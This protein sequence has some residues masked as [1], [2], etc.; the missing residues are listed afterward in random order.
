MNDGELG[1]DMFVEKIRGNN[2]RR[3]ADIKNNK[4][5]GQLPAL[6]KCHFTRQIKVKNDRFS[7]V[8]SAEGGS[9]SSHV[10][11]KLAHTSGDGRGSH[12][13][14]QVTQIAF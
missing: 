5:W 4:R 2:Q 3:R 10:I 11:F 13:D 8:V 14:I 6:A 7:P 9:F 1:D 12:F